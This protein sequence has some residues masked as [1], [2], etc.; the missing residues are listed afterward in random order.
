MVNRGGRVAFFTA[1][2][3]VSSTPSS[4]HPFVHPSLCL[5]MLVVVTLLLLDLVENL[6]GV[7]M[8]RHKSK[9]VFYQPAVP[10]SS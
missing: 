8:N 9:Q 5:N 1:F 7:N 2:Q 6:S 10:V 4:F 3:R